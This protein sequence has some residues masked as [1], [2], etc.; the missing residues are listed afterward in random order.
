MS[1]QTIALAYTRPADALEEA[2]Y[3][4][5][6]EALSESARGR[7]FLVEHARRSRSTETNILLTAIERIEAQVRPRQAPPEVDLLHHELSGVLDDMRTARARIESGGAAPK[8]EQLAALLDILQRRLR[9]LLPSRPAADSP[10][11]PE[12]AAPATP[13]RPAAARWIEEPLEPAPAVNDA[14]PPPPSST[15]EASASRLPPAATIKPSARQGPVFEIEAEIKAVVAA[16][17]E[18]RT[19]G[20][21]ASLGAAEP[22]DA[23]TLT[24]AEDALTAI[25]ALT[26]DE[27][28]ALFT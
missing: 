28:I 6:L 13:P 12:A 16:E 5:L 27:R 11:A 9:K 10:Q 26:E 14:N 18:T 21:P 2:E 15:A 19:I 7:S 17:L 4:A 24:S 23:T 22:V 3:Q 8:A 1:K 20:R 25:M